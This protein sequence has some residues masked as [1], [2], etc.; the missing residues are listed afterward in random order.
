VCRETRPR[1]IVWGVGI[2][3]QKASWVAW[4]LLR[5]KRVSENQSGVLMPDR[6]F[7]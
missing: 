4:Q 2:F 3:L 7:L 5:G 1:R 6:W